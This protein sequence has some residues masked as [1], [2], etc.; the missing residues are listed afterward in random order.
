M[1]AVSY[2]NFNHWHLFTGCTV[3]L[4]WGG[5][6]VVGVLVRTN[7]ALCW[8]VQSSESRPGFCQRLISVFSRFSDSFVTC[9]LVVRHPSL[10][11]LEACYPPL[12][13]PSPAPPQ[14]PAVPDTQRP[15]GQI[16]THE[17]CGTFSNWHM[18]GIMG[19]VHMGA[20]MWIMSRLRN[21]I[22]Q[23]AWKIILKAYQIQ[24]TAPKFTLL[25][26]DR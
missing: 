13:L 25:L 23:L 14:T 4:F 12:L 17:L 8:L 19:I 11:L 9:S 21:Y 18:V 10:C 3:A 2:T 1:Y 16:C 24:T 6:N 26:L 5:L 22:K 20:L 7:Q 15:T